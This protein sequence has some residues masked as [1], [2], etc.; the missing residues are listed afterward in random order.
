MGVE[1]SLVRISV[2]TVYTLV[3]L[4]IVSLGVSSQVGFEEKSLATFRVH[5]EE[6]GLFPMCELVC[7]QLAFKG[8]GAVALRAF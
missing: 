1:V 8:E 3:P 6:A 2:G 7:L 4:F 5:T